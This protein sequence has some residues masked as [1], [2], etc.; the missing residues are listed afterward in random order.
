MF[1]NF[2]ELGAKIGAG[3]SVYGLTGAG[4][5]I[6]LVF[7]GFLAG[8]ARNQK[9]QADLF[10]ITILGFALTEAIALFAIMFAFVVLYS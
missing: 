1:L 2:G 4:I 10:K 6:G 5:G 7:N 9:I 3:C 8:V